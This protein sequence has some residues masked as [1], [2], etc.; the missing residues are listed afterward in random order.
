M[1]AAELEPLARGPVALIAAFVLGTLWGS[2]ANV[3]IY[4]WPPSAAHPRGR[5]VVSPGSHCGACG[6]PVRW[7]DNV[8]ILAWLWLR[9]RCR[10]CG[11][12]FSARYILVEA[13]TGALFA[14]AW[15]F[16]VDARAAL[17]PLDVRVVRFAI[18]AAFAF[19]MVVIMF[20]DLDHKLILDRVTVPSL[21]VFYGLGT[22]LPERSWPDG[23]VGAAVGLALVR[24][25]ADGFYLARGREGMGYGD[26][27]L[28]AVVGAL[29]GWKA[30]L[31]ALFLGATLGTVVMVPSALIRGRRKPPAPPADP[32]RDADEE[33]EPDDVVTWQDRQGAAV[34]LGFLAV[35]GAVAALVP[36][37]RVAV[38]GVIVLASLADDLIGITAPRDGQGDGH[39]APIEDREEGDPPPDGAEIPFGPFLALA[40]LFWWFAEPYVMV[41]L[42]A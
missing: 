18:G 41:R 36:S 2:F 15:W 4:R 7:Y 5:S 17:E 10:D 3:C 28:L 26:G 23:I 24:V 6:Q 20:I 9:G 30:P 1:T 21:F 33:R 29:M 13:L 27:K 25:I 34:A 12:E 22:A 8:P 16:A 32:E 14:V 38:A 40:A 35:A 39:E 11:V 42:A 37:A 19:V 31:V